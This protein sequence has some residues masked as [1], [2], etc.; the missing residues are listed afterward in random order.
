MSAVE[1]KQLLQAIFAELSKGNSRPLVESMADEVCW[2]VAGSTPWSGTYRGKPAV[3]KE[4]LGPL[5]R[6]FAQPYRATADRF[7]AEGDAVTVEARGEATTK[8]GLAY[9]NRYCF[10]YRF[11]DGKLR[12]ITEYCDTALIEAALGSRD[13]TDA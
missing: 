10:I 1:N 6:R 8:D 12:E 2:T 13:H 11:A 5:S 7:I 4:L 3:L 9:N